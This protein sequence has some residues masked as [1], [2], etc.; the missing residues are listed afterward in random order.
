MVAFQHQPGHVWEDLSCVPN[1]SLSSHASA[2]FKPA[3]KSSLSSW[4]MCEDQTPAIC[5]GAA[6]CQIVIVTSL[7]KREES[8]PWPPKIC[9]CHLPQS[10]H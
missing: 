10:C 7:L 4:Q 6:R 3:S 8:A 2:S 1:S 5:L 9:Q